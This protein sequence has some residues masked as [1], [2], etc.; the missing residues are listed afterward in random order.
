MDKKTNQDREPSTLQKWQR[1]FGV[2]YRVVILIGLIAFVLGAVV[3]VFTDLILAWQMV[4]PVI[5]ILIG[6]IL[7]RV[8]FVLYK[9]QK[10]RE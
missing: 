3:V 8:E 1:F 10:T 4:F 2:I 5:L 6:V 9:R 7:A